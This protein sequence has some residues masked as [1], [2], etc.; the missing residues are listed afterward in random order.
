M[1]MSPVRQYSEDPRYVGAIDV[2]LRGAFA[3]L[4]DDDQYRSAEDVELFLWSCKYIVEPLDEETVYGCYFNETF[5][6]SEDEEV[7]E[8][9]PVGFRVRPLEHI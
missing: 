8:I 1:Y 7:E 3:S 4:R 5:E 2:D 9:S 6:D